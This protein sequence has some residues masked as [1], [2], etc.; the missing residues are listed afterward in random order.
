MPKRIGRNW[1]QICERENVKTAVYTTLENR[2]KN[3]HWGKQ[4]Q[5]ILD[6]VEEITD[7]IQ[8]SLTNRTYEFGEV[9]HTTLKERRK[10]RKIDHL[11]V[12]HNIYLQ[13]VLQ[14]T[15]PIFIEKFIPHTY[16]SIVGRGLTQMALDINRVIKAHPDYHFILIDEKKCYE[17]V[18][19]EIMLKTLAHTFKDK[20]LLEFF[21]RLI[22][23]I[24]Q[25]L[26]I[27]YSTNHYFVNL[28][29]TAL[30]WRIY[31]LKDVFI[32]RYMDD[33]LILAPKEKLPSIY[34]ILEEETAKIKQ[35]I[36]PNV[37]F[38][39]IKYGIDLCGYRYYP[40][41]NVLLRNLVI[42]IK[43][44]DREL[45]KANVPDKEYKQQMASYWGWIKY[46]NGL[47]FWKSV[48][49]D[50]IYLFEKEINKMKHF[51]DIAQNEDKEYNEYEGEAISITK[52]VNEPI[53]ILSF[54]EI[55]LKGKDKI[56]AQIE[57]NGEK[58]Y[59]F[60]AAGRVIDLLKKYKEDLPF[61][62]T[63]IERYNPKTNNTYYSLS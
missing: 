35:V 54:K 42:N 13:A 5:Y 27:G 44:K 30:D 55:E 38:A 23:T 24:P 29:F 18:D 61:R 2:K 33:I 59:F 22:A 50:K 8:R 53:T 11:D 37:R 56:I 32:F 20:Y 14:I 26:A 40:D 41:G 12:Y 9:Y 49:K 1:G 63:I 28:L 16:S 17:N 45:R 31:K 34:N 15:I 4:E 58:K 3:K 36:K 51:Q 25:G 43:R 52:L 10:V 47:H 46:C 48:L 19:H 57:H 39:P 7:E 6:H 60:T 62:A 21:E